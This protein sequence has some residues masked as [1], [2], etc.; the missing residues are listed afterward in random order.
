MLKVSRVSKSIVFTGLVIGT[1]LIGGCAGTTIGGPFAAEFVYVAT[2]GTIAQYAVNT[3][4]QLSP[5][6]PAEVVTNVTTVPLVTTHPVWVTASKDAKYSYAAN[7][8]EGTI[9]QYSISTS[10][11]LVSLTPA[12]VTTGTAP[13]AVEVTPDSKHV[14]CLNKTDN[15][16]TQFAVSLTGTLSALAPAS[17]SVP[18]DSNSLV[19]S[20]NGSYLYVASYSTGK[21]SA[22][23]IGASGQLTPLTVPDYPAP[24]ANGQMSFSPDGKYLYVPLSGTGVAQF[25]VGLDGALTPLSP[26]TVSGSIAGPTGA[27]DAFA[28]SADGK[29]GYLGLF[30]GGTPGSPVDQFS[31][32][33][34][35]TLSSLSP[36]SVPAGNAPNW[37]ITEP[38]GHYVFVAN[39]NDHTI[40]EFSVGVGGTLSLESPSFVTPSGALQMA[41]ITR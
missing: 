7:K 30:N 19:I 5:L 24:L 16:V 36:A 38:A 33:A 27:A 37:I 6:T 31:I 4:G 29:F 2:G 14:Y 40:Y 1:G 26:A 9:S 34:N 10:G 11:A 18:A 3:S 25:A 21:I 39:E 20:P 8:N 35:G 32:A 15:T 23:S 13:V 41:V 22:F 12:F 17:V 28:V